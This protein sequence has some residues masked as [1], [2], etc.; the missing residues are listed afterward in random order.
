VPVGLSP[1]E[2]LPGF[3]T[4]FDEEAMKGH[5]QVALFGGDD[6][7]YTVERCTPTRPLYVPGDC[8]VL[9][10]QF[11]ARNSASGGLVDPIVTARVFPDQA[12]CAAYMREKVAPLAARMRG[13]SEV[14][15]FTAPAAV[16]EPLNMVV[17][18]WPIDGELPS[19][20]EATDRRDRK[21]V[22]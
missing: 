7:G 6:A 2:A 10:Y 20:V 1:Q 9:R 22:V 16:I 3:A 4:A 8:C 21:S 13:R 11:E 17:H 5:L 18:V 15:A 19:L 12:T 14:A